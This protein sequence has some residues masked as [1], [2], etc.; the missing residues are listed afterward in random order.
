[1]ES[2]G[3]FD[4]GLGYVEFHGIGLGEFCDPGSVCVLLEQG[5]LIESAEEHSV[6]AD[7]EVV[8]ASGGQVQLFE[9][10]GA[11]GCLI[12]VELEGFAF[13][14]GGEIEPCV[15]GFCGHGFVG[16][17]AARS[18]MGGVI[19]AEGI[20][21]DVENVTAPVSCF[22]CAE[23]PPE[24]P[25]VG[26]DVFI[27]RTVFDGAEPEIVVE[28]G[29]DF[30]GCLSEGDHAAGAVDPTVGFGDVADCA[31]LDKFAD[32]VHVVFCVALHAELCYEFVLLCDLG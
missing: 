12:P 9:Y 32:A 22:A 31:G 27:V 7:E 14:F 30:L 25:S 18:D 11:A 15:H 10:L 23:V 17:G 3:V 20:V 29:G 2:G 13:S 19:E 6:G 1:V 4:V 8:V 28:G 5:A 16:F 26:G 21:G 24:S